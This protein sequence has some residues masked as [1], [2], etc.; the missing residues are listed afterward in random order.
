MSE[1]GSTEIRDLL[2]GYLHQRVTAPERATIDSHLADCEECRL[3]LAMLT[4]VREAMRQRTPVIDTA[5]IVRALPKPQR[6]RA[7]RPWMLQLAAALSFISIGG[8][9]LAV[10]R[11]FYN[12]RR[13]AITQDS[14]RPGSSVDSVPGT[15]V[16]VAIAPGRPGLTVGGGVGDLGADELELLLGALESLEAVPSAEP[17]DLLSQVTPRASGVR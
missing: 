15:G 11:S 3:E 12:D 6:R 17:D 1:C 14:T 10:A 13:A 8:V 5:A 9:S 2:P 16:Q 7:V 4:S